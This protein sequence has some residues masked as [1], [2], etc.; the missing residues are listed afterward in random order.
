MYL[1]NVCNICIKY[2]EIIEMA[3]QNIINYP[4]REPFD[5]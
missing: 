2:N 5:D 4:D 1:C 3:L